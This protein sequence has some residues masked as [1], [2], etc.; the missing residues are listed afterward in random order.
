MTT[1]NS[2]LG[3]VFSCTSEQLTQ[4]FDLVQ[5][6]NLASEI[7][8]N[9]DCSFTASSCVLQYLAKQQK[10]LRDD[11]DAAASKEV[12]LGLDIAFILFSGYLVFGPM[13]LGFA[14]VSCRFVSHMHKG[15]RAVADEHQLLND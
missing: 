13:Q 1:L 7:C 9:Y 4:V 2:A 15:L 14:L 5:D 6:N 10:G 12:S 3:V 11:V 8:K